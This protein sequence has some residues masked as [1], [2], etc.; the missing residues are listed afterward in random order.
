MDVQWNSI[1]NK[2]K[3]LFKHIRTFFRME[4]RINFM[5]INLLVFAHIG[6]YS[7]LVLRSS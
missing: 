4:I 5:C 3:G 1:S 6:Q 7:A 2:V